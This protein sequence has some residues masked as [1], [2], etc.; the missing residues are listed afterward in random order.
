MFSK[1]EKNP[2]IIK[3]TILTVDIKK[4][5]DDQFKLK[6]KR[7]KYKGATSRVIPMDQVLIFNETF[8]C[9]C[10][11]YTIKGTNQVREK[12]IKFTLL[13][14]DTNDETSIFGTVKINLSEFFG[15]Q[16]P[17]ACTFPMTSKH[18]KQPMI[19]ASFVFRN[20]G[21]PT[22]V[23][24]I[25]ELDYQSSLDSMISSEKWDTTET[26]DAKP[27]IAQFKT[28]RGTSQ[29]QKFQRKNDTKARNPVSTI[30]PLMP[31]QNLMDFMGMKNKAHKKLFESILK[32]TWPSPLTP[33]FISMPYQYPP[34]VFPIF[35]TILKSRIFKADEEIEEDLFD[36]IIILLQKSPL[37]VSCSNE[38][39]FITFLVL[40]I[41]LN[42]L[43]DEYE[44]DKS[45]IESFS[46]KFKPIVDNSLI[47]FEKPLLGKTEQFYS[48]FLEAKSEIPD[49]ITELQNCIKN[50][51]NNLML[52]TP[53]KN[54]VLHSF[55]SMVDSRLLTKMI[56]NPTL[57]T[58]K[59]AMAWSSFLTAYDSSD[60]NLVLASEASKM[61][62]MAP[63]IGL[64]PEL[65]NE[66]CPHLSPEV[67]LFLLVHVRPDD[68]MAQPID[69]SKFVEYF[70][71]QVNSEQINDITPLLDIDYLEMA[72]SI[73][74]Q[75]WCKCEL[76][77]EVMARYPFF[78][79][80]LK[81]EASPA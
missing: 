71:V 49:L 79:E 74:L 5:I 60:D 57:L 10:T 76:Q 39:R 46:E 7:G 75:D 11:M 80:Y 27:H 81:Y 15:K 72:S 29:L 20:F 69:A 77:G 70:D 58:F 59:N 18:S 67:V 22:D 45:R 24:D 40:Y 3:F 53:I 9:K 73:R 54:A 64:H 21:Q 38:K 28:Q 8:E 51:Q 43:A 2:C 32:S 47:A 42:T 31:S 23:D 6:W 63:T 19:A 13:R 1:W 56:T 55:K 62:M 12:D 78:H 35:A 25:K 34:A 61:L 44:L 14:L 30:S 33:S 36:M 65:A 17:T 68:L 50:V 26:A 48:I 41:L 16:L 66:I 4:N 37:S 52:P